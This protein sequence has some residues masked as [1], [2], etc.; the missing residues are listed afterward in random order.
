MIRVRIAAIAAAASLVCVAATAPVATAANGTGSQF[1]AYNFPALYTVAVT[2]K[3]SSGKSVTGTYGIQRFVS[4]NGKAYSVG[5]FKG[6][7]AG[8]HFTRYG[9]MM[10]AGVNQN[11]MAPS[12]RAHAAQSCPILNLTLGPIH[13]NLLGL[14]INTNQIN[15]NITAVSGQGLLG[16]LLCS[17]S[18]AL[19]TGG[20][21]G[22]IEGDLHSLVGLLNGILGNLGGL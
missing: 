4:R 13:L 12:R 22:Q 18:N 15:V 10:P 5:T 3:T 19:S 17:V 9:V 11:A 1:R 8:H 7:F 6:T 14:V 2:G 21:L 20:L 16:D